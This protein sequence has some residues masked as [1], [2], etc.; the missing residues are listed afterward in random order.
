[1][2][3]CFPN[4]RTK[5]VKVWTPT[6]T[7]TQTSEFTIDPTDGD[8]CTVF[9]LTGEVD[10]ARNN[11][12]CPNLKSLLL[13]IKPLVHSMAIPVRPAWK[14]RITHHH[15]IL[16]KLITLNWTPQLCAN[17]ILTVIVFDRIDGIANQEN[18]QLQENKQF[19]LRFPCKPL[20]NHYLPI[21]DNYGYVRDQNAV[22]L[23]R[24]EYVQF[25]MKVFTRPD[26]RNQ[27]L[28]FSLIEL[29]Q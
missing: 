18:Y 8:V 26:A 9:S 11:L 6:Q 27:H 28:S 21:S 17:T 1:M 5:K 4:R 24:N 19:E 16:N 10:G 20:L 13:F 25:A 15:W 14:L 2:C 12:I 3:H 22:Y 7:P 23:F 29:S